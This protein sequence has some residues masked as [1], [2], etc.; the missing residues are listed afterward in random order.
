[1]DK[2]LYLVTHLM[3]FIVSSQYEV[4]LSIR[5]FNQNFVNLSVKQSQKK[6]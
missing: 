1:M 3:K 2:K 6:R 4:T 5:Q